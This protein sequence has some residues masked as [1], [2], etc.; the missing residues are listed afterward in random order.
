MKNLIIKTALLMCICLTVSGNSDEPQVQKTIPIDHKTEPKDQK[1]ESDIKNTM[2]ALMQAFNDRDADKLANLWTQDAVLYHSISGTTSN[3]KD[4]IRGYYKDFF[5]SENNAKVDITVD[6]VSTT[7]ENK[8][9]VEGLIRIYYPNK[10]SIQGAFKSNVEKQDGKWLIHDLKIIEFEKASSNFEHLKNLDWFVGNWVDDDENVDIIF[11][12]KWDKSKN[13][14]TQKFTLSL[15][16]QEALE[17]FQIIAWDP[18]KKQVRSWVFDSDGG[19]GNGFW[20]E[21]GDSWQA[22]MMYTLSDGK[23]ASAV[24][25]YKKID[26]NS[27]TFSSTGRDIDGVILPDIQP[28]KVV[29]IKG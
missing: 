21:N 9:F 17:G 3:G 18:A 2:Q 13:F 1:S 4:E 27:Y 19:F 23:T 22:N 14:L 15:L 5:N 6:R 10:E 25:I 26:E 12:V 11:N 8:A 7:E 24:L 20:N 28:V 16:G 29:R